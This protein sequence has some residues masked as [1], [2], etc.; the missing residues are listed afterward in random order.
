[1]KKTVILSF[2]VAGTVLVSCKKAY[3]CECITT[4][5]ETVSGVV[6]EKTYKNGST[7]YGKKMTKKQAE[8]A[9]KHEGE[10]LHSSYE[11]F[12]TEN[13]NSPVNDVTTT[14]TCSLK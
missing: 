4:D 14:T 11:S 13:G 8:A 9:C 12:L 10:A 1:M 7:A 3:T 6:T 2:I 5:K